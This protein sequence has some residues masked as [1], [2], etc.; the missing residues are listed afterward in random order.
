MTR[1]SACVETTH[2]SATIEWR[3]VN[4]RELFV[5]V[6]VPANVGAEVRIPCS[7]GEQV[8]APGTAVDL[9]W[10]NGARR[11]TIAQGLHEFRRI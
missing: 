1:A 10:R 11:F 8:E 3:L 6:R 4:A 5:K 9:G 7:E 2:G